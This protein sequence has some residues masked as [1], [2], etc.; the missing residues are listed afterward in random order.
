MRIAIPL[1]FALAISGCAHIEPAQQVTVSGT[2]IEESGKYY[3][4]GDDSRYHLNAM[5]QLRYRQY[6]GRELVIRGQVPSECAQAWRDAV[7]KVGDDAELVD[8]GKVDWSPCIAPHRV[9]L[10]T[11]DGRELVYDWE[12][13]D[14]EDY[15]F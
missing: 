10:V 8:W 11:T 3:L 12:K 4:H 6:L 1:L 14:L 5:P 15:Y 7:V 13:I 9:D 2:L